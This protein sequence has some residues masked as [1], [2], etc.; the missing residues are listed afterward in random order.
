MLKVLMSYV[1]RQA[2]LTAKQVKR[3]CE[4]MEDYERG[5]LAD[6]R[7]Q[8]VI[9]VL[10]E[11]DSKYDSEQERII[12]VHSN[13][14]R[15]DFS[16]SD[17]NR[18]ILVGNDIQGGTFKNAT[19]GKGADLSYARLDFANFSSADLSETNLSGACL[20]RAELNGSNLSGANLQ[21]AD[22]RNVINATGNFAGANLNGAD[23]RQAELGNAKGL[24][25]K[26]LSQAILDCDTVL[27]AEVSEVKKPLNCSP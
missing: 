11:R 24:T 8:A 13:L 6:Y 27:P 25:A 22:L 14:R 4:P 2:N 16:R 10:R 19:L 5:E 23:L 18:A 17:L 7:V 9:D 12:I 20:V 3:D 1:Q 21:G 15:V 26:Q